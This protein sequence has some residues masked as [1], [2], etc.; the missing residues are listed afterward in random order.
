MIHAILSALALWASSAH[1]FIDPP[2]ITPEHPTTQTAIEI[3]IRY[4]ICDGLANYTLA[5]EDASVD[6]TI[7]KIPTQDD[8]FCNNPINTAVIVLPLLLEGEH[9]LRIYLQD[10][11]PPDAQP[12]LWFQTILD[13]AQAGGTMPTP[14]PTLSSWVSFALLLLGV[15]F[16]VVRHRFR[17][18]GGNRL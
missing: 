6:L 3:S 13:I 4:G 10:V 5:M 12:V 8:P 14:I 7:T 2:V 18:K 1:A 15:L 16:L 17:P 9:S 11:D